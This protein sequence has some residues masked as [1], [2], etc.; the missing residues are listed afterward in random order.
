MDPWG[1][2]VSPQHE[3]MTC[4]SEK[5]VFGRRNLAPDSTQ[6]R[7]LNVSIDVTKADFAP[8]ILPASNL[9]VVAAAHEEKHPVAGNALLAAVL[10]I[11]LSACFYG[12]VYTV[13]WA[14][15]QALLS[16]PPSGRRRD[17]PILFC[18]RNSDRQVARSCC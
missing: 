11:T 5:T 4:L 15:L 10:G 17:R 12:L 13:P 8:N 3:L 9:G 14:P 6:T 18:R 16:Q 1:A 2:K 7:A